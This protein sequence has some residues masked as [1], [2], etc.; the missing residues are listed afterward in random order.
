MEEESEESWK[1]N[2]GGIWEASGDIWEA[3]GDI[4]DFCCSRSLR[5]ARRAHTK[6]QQPSN[7]KVQKPK[8][9]H[10]KGAL[11]QSIAPHWNIHAHVNNQAEV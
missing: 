10:A 4:W 8:E 5:C 11:A 9:E 3:S 6:L 2:H 1:S 7:V